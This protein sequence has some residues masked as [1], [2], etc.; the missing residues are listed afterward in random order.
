MESL[1]S[2]LLRSCFYRGASRAGALLLSAK[3]AESCLTQ[4]LRELKEEQEQ[5]NTTATEVPLN[6]ACRALD[7]A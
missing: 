1:L 7:K 3:P 4:L 2:P 6:P 5:V